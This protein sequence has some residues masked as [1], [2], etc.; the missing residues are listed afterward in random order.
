MVRIALSVATTIAIMASAGKAPSGA[1]GS[2]L[3]RA[4]DRA[5]KAALRTTPDMI[6]PT[7]RFQSHRLPEITKNGRRPSLAPNPIRNRR[8]IPTCAG[9][10]GRPLRH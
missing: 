3:N 8:P 2:Q 9:W 7:R 5:K 10:K 6:A 1:A 4:R